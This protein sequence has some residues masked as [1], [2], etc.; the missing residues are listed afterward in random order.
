MRY[1]IFALM[2]R[3]A[4]AGGIGGGIVSKEDTNHT[5]KTKK[6]KLRKKSSAC[7]AARSGAAVACGS[8]ARTPAINNAKDKYVP[9]RRNNGT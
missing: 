7:F 4:Y 3:P 5:K 6:K 9:H 1:A 8:F 2:V